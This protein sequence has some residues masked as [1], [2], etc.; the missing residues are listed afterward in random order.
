MAE[1][2]SKNIG[3][4][5]YELREQQENFIDIKIGL[6]VNGVV[7]GRCVRMTSQPSVS[8]LSI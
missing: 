8:R 5:F 3:K 4:G 2:I 6:I 1:Y 7:R